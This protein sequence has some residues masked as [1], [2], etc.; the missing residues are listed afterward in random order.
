M[1]TIKLFKEYLEHLFAGRRANARELI[2]SAHD[3]GFGAERLLSLVVWPAMEQI[4]ELH[5]QNHIDRITEHL[6][7]RINRQM[8]SQLQTV[9]PRKPKDGRRLVLLCGDDDI[10]ELG[11]QI[12]ADLFESEGWTVFFVGPG[13]AND[14]VLKFCGKVDPDL[15][16][17]YASL[18]PEVPAVR[19]LITLIREVG[20]CEDMQIMVCGGIYARAEELGEEIMADLTAQNV[21]DAIR[22][23]DENPTRVA[24][25]RTLEPGRRRK[26]KRKA[27]TA[28]VEKLRQELGV[29]EDE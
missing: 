16:I 27:F 18:G 1:E 22:Q 15:L 5:R 2:F 8:A 3:R 23:A 9:L 17:V 26:R 21:R 10:S 13:V 7:T 6:A 12:C 24:R 28:R 4:D 29:A 20:I 11:A 19:K 14:E 25:D